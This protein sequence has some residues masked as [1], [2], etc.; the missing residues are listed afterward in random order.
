[1]MTPVIESDYVI[2]CTRK[3]YAI[4]LVL[5]STC[6]FLTDNSLQS[7]DKDQQEMLA[8]AEKPRDAVVSKCTA[9]S[10]G[11]PC[12]SRHRTPWTRQMILY[13]VQCCYA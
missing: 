3:L 1:M 9:A 10:R 13:S 11:P 2:T 8:L 5:S 12:D 7:A 6:H 4:W